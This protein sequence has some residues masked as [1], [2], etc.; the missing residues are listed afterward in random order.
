M[1]QLIKRNVPKFVIN[2]LLH[3]FSRSKASTQWNDVVRDDFI[4]I[5]GVR[6]GSPNFPLLFPVYMGILMESLK[7]SGLGSK[8]NSKFFGCIFY[9]NDIELLL[10]TM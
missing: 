5:G 3:W 1:L 2:V 6:Q 9:A 8:I 4:I 10:F 7:V